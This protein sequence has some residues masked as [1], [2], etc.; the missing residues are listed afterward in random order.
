[1][2]FPQVIS[3]PVSAARVGGQSKGAAVRFIGAVVNRWNRHRS[4]MAWNRNLPRP[5]GCTHLPV[6]LWCRHSALLTLRAGDSLR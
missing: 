5:A 4:L 1:M 3:T 6:R 2:Y